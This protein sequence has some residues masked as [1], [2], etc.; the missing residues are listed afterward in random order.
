[1]RGLPLATTRANLDEIV[2]ELK[3]AGAQVVLAGMTLP[4]NYG[5]QYIRQFEQVYADLAKKHSVPL[6]PF[7]LV[8][9][10]ERG[11]HMQPDQLHPTAEGHRI[12]AQT[13]LKAVKPLLL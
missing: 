7:L 1:L 3:G 13:V 6:I 2:T 10:A 12:M 11:Q 9:F 8:G 5:A 4:R